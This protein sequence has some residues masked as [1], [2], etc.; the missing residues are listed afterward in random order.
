MF[1][2]SIFMLMV[3]ALAACS[4][5]P[6]SQD[7]S[8]MQQKVDEYAK[9]TLTT[10]LTKLTPKEKEMLPLL[11]QAAEIM[12]ELYWQQAWGDKNVHPDSLTD[13]AAIAFFNINYGPVS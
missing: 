3:V 7:K 11:I 6:A 8:P 12:D 5:K 10:D 4:T 13:S 1:K 2:K 9:F